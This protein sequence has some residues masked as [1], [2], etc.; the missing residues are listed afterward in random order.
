MATHAVKSIIKSLGGE[1]EAREYLKR[2]QVSYE[3]LQNPATNFEG[4]ITLKLSCKPNHA[5]ELIAWSETEAENKKTAP[6][7]RASVTEMIAGLR[8]IEY[9]LLKEFMEGV[10]PG[11]GRSFDGCERVFLA[12][13]RYAVYVEILES[14]ADAKGKDEPE[15]VRLQFLA[16]DYEKDALNATLSPRRSTDPTSNLYHQT[17]ASAWADTARRIRREIEYLRKAEAAQGTVEAKR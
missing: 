11:R 16:D 10:L 3:G 8:D 6:V 2:Q 5:V 7:E 15:L 14:L 12:A 9:H 13:A 4:W 17:L 1:K